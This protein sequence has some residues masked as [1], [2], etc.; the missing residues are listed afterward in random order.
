MK[1]FAIRVLYSEAFCGYIFSYSE[2]CVTFFK[3]MVYIWY[4]VYRAP[5]LREQIFHFFPTLYSPGQYISSLLVS[6]V[7]NKRR[8]NKK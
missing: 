4:L 5:Y 3:L 8:R 1:L 6:I 7:L 2:A